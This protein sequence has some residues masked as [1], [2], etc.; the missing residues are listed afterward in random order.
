LSPSVDQSLLAALY[1]GNLS[2]PWVDLIVGVSF[3][4]SG[5]MMFGLLPALFIRKFRVPAAVTLVMLGLVSGVV[6]LVKPI[7]G[8]VR[9]CQALSWAHSLPLSVP[10]D[11]SFPSGHAAGSF[12]FAT[13]VLTLNRRAGAFLVPIAVVIA[14]SRVA[15]GVHYPSDVLAGAIL[16]SALGWGSA[17]LY[18]LWRERNAARVSV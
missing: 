8:R 15:L 18:V 14:L 7:A 4:G 1:A 6:A 12:A 16:G 3:L 13:F 9:P 17:R 10:I 5:W 2:A 11:C